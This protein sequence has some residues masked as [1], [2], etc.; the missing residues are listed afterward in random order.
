MMHVRVVLGNGQKFLP[1]QIKDT[2]MFGLK[3]ILSH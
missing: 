1:V 3:T 2:N